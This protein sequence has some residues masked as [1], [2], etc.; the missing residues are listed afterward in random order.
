ML[1]LYCLGG[2]IFPGLA[3]L[4]AAPFVGRDVSARLARDHVRTAVRTPVALAAPILAISAIA[5]SMMV[6]L[7]FAADWVTALDREQ[8]AT[9]YVVEHRRRR[10]R[11]RPVGPGCRWPTRGSR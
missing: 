3:G 4:V 5:G 10:P 1:G 6:S 11:G 7:S 8:L 2:W 9:P